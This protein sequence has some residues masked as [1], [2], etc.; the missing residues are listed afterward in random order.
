MYI[1][2][3]ISLSLYMCMYICI[4]IY[5]YIYIYMDYRHV[6]PALAPPGR[7]APVHDGSAQQPA[8]LPQREDRARLSVGS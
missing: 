1:A 5:I 6:Q 4:Y 8:P 2:R 7:G 3:Y